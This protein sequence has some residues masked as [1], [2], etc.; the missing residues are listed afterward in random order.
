[1]PPAQFWPRYDAGEFSAAASEAD[2]KDKEKEK[3]KDKDKE[4]KD[5]AA[6]EPGA[7]AK[8][9]SDGKP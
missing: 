7:P 4:K 3:D 1:M 5:G 6:V 9:T 2:D 8:S